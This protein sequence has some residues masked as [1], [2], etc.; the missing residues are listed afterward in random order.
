MAA[1]GAAVERGV[2]AQN[3]PAAWGKADAEAYFAACGAVERLTHVSRK[4]LALMTFADAAGAAKAVALDGATPEGAVEPLAVAYTGRRANEN[5]DN[6]GGVKRRTRST[7]KPVESAQKRKRD[8]AEGAPTE[9]VRQKRMLE[10]PTA[11]AGPRPT[12][13]PEAAAAKGEGGPAEP[14]RTT[15]DEQNAAFSTAEA[16]NDVAVFEAMYRSCWRHAYQTYPASPW[17][18]FRAWLA[19]QAGTAVDI[20]T[21]LDQF[22]STPT[23]PA[24]APAGAQGDAGSAAVEALP[25]LGI[26]PVKKKKKKERKAA[27]STLL[28]FIDEV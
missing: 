19:A 11:A 2:V 27:A 8:E 9:A 26:L 17:A 5:T 24:P 22:A 1:E 25:D 4:A 14:A 6:I 16:A 23:A 21:I 28:H 15:A 12:A 13:S 18:N 7:A 20:D 10:E 3:L